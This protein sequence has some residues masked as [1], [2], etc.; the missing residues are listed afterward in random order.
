MPR[1]R[2]DQL[3]KGMY[4]QSTPGP[5]TYVAV[6]RQASPPDDSDDVADK[7]A[8]VNYR[9]ALVINEMA[10]R[11]QAVKAGLDEIKAKAKR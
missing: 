7:L 11:L 3:K 10:Q 8:V 5:E 4:M 9:H 1:Y 6:K 2:P